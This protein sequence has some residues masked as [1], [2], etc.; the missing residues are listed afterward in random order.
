MHCRSPV[1]LAARYE[2]TLFKAAAHAFSSRG[3]FPEPLRGLLASINVETLSP[4]FNKAVVSFHAQPFPGGLH[5]TYLLHL[6]TEK[7]L[8]YA[9]VNQA[10]CAIRFLFAAVLGQRTVAFEIPMAKVPQRL[11]QILTREEVRRL[12][13]HSRDLRSRTLLT[14]AY[15]AGLRL[16]ELC[17]LEVSDIES[18]PDRMCLK[19]RQGKGGK[20]RYTLL[21][22]RLLDALRGYWRIARPRIWLFPNHDGDETALGTDHNSIGQQHWGQTTVLSYTPTRFPPESAHAPP[23][24]HH[25]P[26]CSPACHPAEQ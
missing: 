2:K 5:N 9:S 16:S 15:A 22:P 25:P 18:A 6:I 23:P 11:P 14:T 10:V 4:I 8:A 7:K 13:A 20:D 21:S 1:W 24:P 12:L 17:A 19:V 26:P 3:R